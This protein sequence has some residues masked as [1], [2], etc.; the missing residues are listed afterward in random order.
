METLSLIDVQKL[1]QSIYQ[2]YTLQDA[3]TFGVA[4][5]QIVDQLVP[6]DL[7]MFSR[8]D[9]TQLT[10]EDT[11]LPGDSGLSAE[12]SRLRMQSVVED[13]T[14]EHLDLAQR[15]ICKTS[16]FITSAE[17]HRRELLYQQFFRPLGFEDQ[18]TII[19]LNP[20]SQGRDWQDCV[21]TE[22]TGTAFFL[23]RD[24]CS[25]TERDRQLLT[26]LRPHIFQAYSNVR[27][28]QQLEQQLAQA[29]QTISVMGSATGSAMGLIT[30][31]ADGKADRV[32]PQAEVWLD[33]YF[34]PATVPG[35]LPEPLGSWITAQISPLSLPSHP[36]DRPLCIDQGDRRL[37]IRL[38]L[39]AMGDP[40]SL[41]LEEQA[42][43]PRPALELLNLSPKETEVLGYLL[44]G[45]D[46][47]S[48]ARAMAVCTSTIRKHLENIYRKLNVQSRAEAVST[49]L[50]RLG[51]FPTGSRA[52][53]SEG[54]IG[55]SG[56]SG[57]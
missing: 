24:A 10:A 4:A 12:F 14:S 16:D 46:N 56:P 49:T 52:L 37:V 44:E 36:P 51:M 42:D 18:M 15:A 30:L 33:Q 13:P 45:K 29:N 7:P 3:A 9:M 40:H 1:N 23:H 5:L 57:R 21:Y 47:K 2:L 22:L 54:P 38:I 27:K 34:T 17:L 53:G 39:A 28:Y 25:F 55:A 35:G 48:I 32:T 26:L 41:L 31:T 20:P 43:H 50:S 19:Q 11:Y 6:G 8:L